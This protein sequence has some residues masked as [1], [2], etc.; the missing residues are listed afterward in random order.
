[1]TQPFATPD[2]PATSNPSP[3]HGTATGR[4][5][6]GPYA[7][8][9]R[10]FLHVDVV[11]GDPPVPVSVWRTA[12]TD[13]DEAPIRRRLAQRIVAAYS[14]P[15]RAVVDF[16]ADPALREA[17]TAAGRVYLPLTHPADLDDL[18]GASQV[19]LIVLRWPRPTRV[20]GTAAADLFRAFRLVVTPD[21][22]AV[23]VVDPPQPAARY[24]EH[25]H[26]LVPHAHAGGMGYLQHIVAVTVPISGTVSDGANWT[27][28]A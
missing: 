17:V 21:G 16:D 24:V 15:G 9:H 22:F 26:G 28:G 2:R 19:D 11:A 10:D 5:A 13:D 1:M 25:T 12:D 27:A 23:V 6:P 4:D 3:H 20:V 14:R 7:E 18:D 8:R